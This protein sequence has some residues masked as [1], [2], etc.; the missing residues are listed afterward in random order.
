MNTIEQQPEEKKDLSLDEQ[1]AELAELY[2]DFLKKDT[3]LGGAASLWI[4]LDP[5]KIKKKAKNYILSVD[6]PQKKWLIEN[7]KDKV[8]NIFINKVAKDSEYR[9]ADL[10]KM[11]SLIKLA[12]DNK[13]KL[14]KMKGQIQNGEM[15]SLDESDKT[16]QVKNNSSVEKSSVSSTKIATEMVAWVVVLSPALKAIREKIE[17]H[18]DFAN[19]KEVKNADGKK[20]LECTAET[21]YIN[22]KA[23]DDLLAFADAFYQKTGQA[24][25]LNSAYRTIEHQKK[26]KANNKAPTAEAGESG[27]NLGLSID[28]EKNDKNEKAVGWLQGFRELAKQYHFNPIKSEDWHFDHDVLPKPDDRLAMAKSLDT[29]FQ[30]EKLAA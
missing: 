19:I 1:K 18:E 13:E 28:I 12:G 2:L 11:K 14:E 25:S 22:V 27:H 4:K 20:I 30:E 17:I 3:L 23:L 10:D 16:S 9:R 6:K 29:E 7:I 8:S 24:L 5:L 21:P 15:P 26:L